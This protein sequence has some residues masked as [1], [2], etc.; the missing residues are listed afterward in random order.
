M[1]HP[2]HIH[3]ITYGDNARQAI[4][5]LSA[6]RNAWPTAPVTILD[7]ARHPIDD[8]TRHKLEGGAAYRCTRWERGGNLRGPAC[9]RGLL[10]EYR[11]AVR[12]GAAYVL[13]L[14]ADTLVLNSSPI[15]AMMAQ[16]IDYGTHTTLDAPWGG[17]CILLSAFAVERLHLAAQRLTMPSGCRE[18]ITQGALAT[19]CGLHVCS[20]DGNTPCT[21]QPVFY[22]G[23]D[24]HQYNDSDYMARIARLVAVASVGTSRLTGAPRTTE[25]LAAQALLESLQ[26]NMQLKATNHS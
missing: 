14:D 23:I 11:R 10:R 8:D 16:G 5:A 17:G 26:K 20:L 6:V 2:L 18:D 19:A 15:M 13:K 9:I 24:T 1:I 12:A 7:D 4:H 21:N 25:A 22:T 3:I